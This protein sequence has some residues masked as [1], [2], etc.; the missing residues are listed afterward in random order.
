MLYERY[1][2]LKQYQN[3]QDLM[4]QRQHLMSELE[5]SW[6][7]ANKLITEFYSSDPTLKINNFYKIFAKFTY[8]IVYKIEDTVEA[9]SMKE[10]H[11]LK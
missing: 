1:R 2:F 6:F 8:L 4:S 11:S 9:L 10:I 5:F 7:L 3:K